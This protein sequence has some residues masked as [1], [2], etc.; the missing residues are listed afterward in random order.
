MG[1]SI[2]GSSRV[3]KLVHTP[4]LIYYRIHDE[5]RAV[6]VLHFRHGSRKPPRFWSSSRPR[7][8]AR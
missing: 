2:H 5:N 7:R 3:R 8:T 6:E 4:I 1:S